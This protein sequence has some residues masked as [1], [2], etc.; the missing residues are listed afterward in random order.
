MEV[1]EASADYLAQAVPKVPKGYKQTEVGVIPEDWEVVRLGEHVTFRT[2]PFGT[3]LHKSDYTHNGI[4]VINPMHIVAGKIEPTRTMTI[5]EQA[6]SS[7]S[8]FRFKAGEL[9][10]GRRGDMGRC[11]VVQ[12]DQS[13]WLCG[14]GSMIIRP[15]DTDADFLQRLLSSPGTIADI[16]EASV[17]TTMINLNQATLAGL[18]IQFPP[19]T[20]QRAIAAVLSDVDSL[21]AKLDQLIAKK[22]DLKQAA[23]QQLLTGLTRLSGFSGEWE[24]GAI[25]KQIDL[26]TGFPFSSNSYSENGVRL[27]RGSNVKRGEVDWSEDL[28]QCWTKITSDIAKYELQAGDLVIAMDGSLVGRSYAILTTTDLPALLLQRVA[29]IRSKIIDIGFLGQFVGSAHFIN[30]CDSV[31]TVTAIPH[32]SASDIRNFRIPIPPTYSEQ[33]AIAT[34]LSDMDTE[35]TA[36]DARRKKTHLLKQGM[37]QELLTGG[38]RLV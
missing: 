13:G 19:I 17:G 14:T 16:E 33:I 32:I 15:V 12:K 7:L 36:L 26:L 30:Y 28:V 3:A 35:I 8:D 29:R 18:K 37:M 2:G 22:R 21:L 4:P 25:G 24:M 38:I 23:M 5:T 27:L 31:K 34:V 1:R 20:E 9:V 11:A 6:A 10:I